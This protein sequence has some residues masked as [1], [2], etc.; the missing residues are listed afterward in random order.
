MSQRVR[1]AALLRVRSMVV[2]VPLAVT[3]QRLSVILAV[4]GDRVGVEAAEPTGAPTTARLRADCGEDEP[5]TECPYEIVD[6]GIAVLPVMG[7]FV[8]RAS[9]MDA[10]S[11]LTSYERLQSQLAQAVADPAVRGILLQVDSPGGETSG[12]LDAADAV[13]AAAAQKPL[14]AIADEMACSAA[15]C[16]ASAAARIY[17][18]RTGWVGSVGTVA[19]HVDETGADTQAGLK[20][21]FV[22]AGAQKTELSSHVALSK[23]AR[24]RLQ[25]KV[26]QMNALLVGAVAQRRRMAVE[27]V[28]ALE[29]G[30][31]I[32]AEAIAA[33]LADAVGD[34]PQALSAFRA[35]LDTQSGAS[36]APGGT[37]MRLT[38]QTDTPVPAETAPDETMT[39]EQGGAKAA[40][41]QE[42]APAAA[43]APDD[44]PAA[45]ASAEKPKVVSIA[46][47]QAAEII[48]LCCL[49][50]Q[51]KLA[52]T[53]I[54]QN[55]TAEA[56]RK[57]LLAMRAEADAAQR[58][59]STVGPAGA[60]QAKTAADINVFQ[61][62]ADR[63]QAQTRQSG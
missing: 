12:M 9:W 60:P 1:K 20:Y 24:A 30:T 45:S 36:R 26:D 3:P 25:A 49:A 35:A 41:T 22:Q 59:T 11:G 16:L 5:G 47:A 27:A 2:G 58:V 52:S 43:P 39:T 38:S 56:V 32:G 63:R 33:G 44:P 18:P 53:F 14:W 54:E 7:T 46:T 57:Q 13:A 55:L 61:V 15:Y 29:A 31:F 48:D 62:Y 42:V 10:M 21:A 4:I 19:V 34:L 37:G 6:G 50:G 17:V 28:L 8:K 40:P 23:D 51:P